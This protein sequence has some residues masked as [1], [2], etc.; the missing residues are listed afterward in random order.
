MLRLTSIKK[1]ELT[2]YQL[3]DVAQTRKCTM[4]G[5]LGT[6]GWS[7]DL[8]D[9]QESL[10][11]RFFPRKMREAKVKEFINLRQTGMSVPDFSVKFTKLSVY[12]P[13]LLSNPSDEMSRFLLV[14]FEDLV[15]EF[16]SAMI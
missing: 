8:G 2:A 12:D 3:N 7:G 4:E 15:E 9:L 16:R 14:L 1:S 5:Y 13:S 10:L 6:K 11:H